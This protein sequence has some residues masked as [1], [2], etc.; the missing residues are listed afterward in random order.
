MQKFNPLFDPGPSEEPRSRP[1][2]NRNDWDNQSW[3]TYS[4]T[5]ARR[6]LRRHSMAVSHAPSGGIPRM[7]APSMAASNRYLAVSTLPQPTPSEIIPVPLSQ[8]SRNFS[9]TQSVSQIE[10]W[11]S[12]DHIISPT[13]DVEEVVPGNCRF[14]LGLSLLAF[15]LGGAII[16]SIVL[17]RCKY[18][19]VDIDMR[20]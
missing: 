15:L 20:I 16:A 19:G 14:W 5:L 13:N 2:E 9:G 12:S 7:Y 8:Q 10:R 17:S 1:N 3:V 11:R 4:S 18:K 6:D